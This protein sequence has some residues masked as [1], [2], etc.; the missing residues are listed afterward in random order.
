MALT[1]KV[2][3]P[4]K[5]HPTFVKVWNA[6][7]DDVTRRENFK[8]GHL[9]QLEILCDMYVEME[10]LQDILELSGYSYESEVG[11][12]GGTI[13]R[14]RPELN[15]LNRTRAEIRNYSKTLGLL[16]VRDSDFNPGADDDTD[17]DD[18]V[19]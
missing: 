4:P 8:R 18:F 9:Y 12:G 17:E 15:Q 14:I 19:E 5:D 3:M 11:R 16:L 2:F 7:V 6:Y 1:K 10:K 13:T